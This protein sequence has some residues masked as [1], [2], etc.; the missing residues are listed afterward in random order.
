MSITPTLLDSYDPNGATHTYDQLTSTHTY[1]NPNHSP[2]HAHTP[3][4]TRKL[5]S[6]GREM[7][8]TWF[9]FFLDLG[10]NR[11]KKYYG[12]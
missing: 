12:L 6:F 8:R 3:Q 1:S 11:N 2:T 10:K 7:C 5:R 4:Y 9:R